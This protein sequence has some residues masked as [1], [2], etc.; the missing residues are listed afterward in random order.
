MKRMEP[1]ARTSITLIRLTSS[2]AIARRGSNAVD[3]EAHHQAVLL[4]LD[5]DV[6][7]KLL[8]RLEQ[9]DRRSGS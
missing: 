9:R 2:G 5:M 8:D 6:G 4:R 3:A 7:R 1:P